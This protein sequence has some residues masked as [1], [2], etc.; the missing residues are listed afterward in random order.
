MKRARFRLSL[1]K[2]TGFFHP[3]R[4]MTLSDCVKAVVSQV[5]RRAKEG[6]L[7]IVKTSLTQ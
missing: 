3:L 1:Q 5:R 6:D 7:R 4:R 2:Y